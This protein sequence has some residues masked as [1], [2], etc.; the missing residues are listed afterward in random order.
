MKSTGTRSK[1]NQYVIITFKFITPSE[2]KNGKIASMSA[3][4]QKDL[5]VPAPNNLRILV[6]G[7]EIIKGA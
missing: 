7:N 6:R 5:N 1:S 3:Q 2:K 4:C